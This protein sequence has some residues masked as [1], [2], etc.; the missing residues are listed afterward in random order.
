MEAIST[1]ELD[2]EDLEKVAQMIRSQDFA[3]L[4]T[5]YEEALKKQNAD[6]G[7]NLFELIS[8]YYYRETLHTHILYS[9]LDP[10]GKHDAKDHYLHLFLEFIRSQGAAIEVDDYESAE[11]E[12]EQ[13]K[14]D[15]LILGKKVISGKRKAI[16][17]ENKINCAVDQPRQLPGYLQKLKNRDNGC[18]KC[19][20][21][22]YLRLNGDTPPGEHGWLEDEKSDVKSLLTIISAYN[23]TDNDLRTG[24]IL[25]C[26]DLRDVGTSDA[27][28][29]LGQY[30][31]I[32]RKLGA[33]IMNEPIMEQF[34]LKM[35]DGGNLKTA[36]HLKMMLDELI[37]YRVKQI[38]HNFSLNHA[39]FDELYFW[40]SN[41]AVFKL[42]RGTHNLQMVVQANNE[43]YSL[44]FWDVNFTGTG[45]NVPEK[46]LNK[47]D[48]F[49]DYEYENVNR[50]FQLKKTFAFPGQEL[51]LKQHIE[52]FSEKLGS[53]LKGDETVLP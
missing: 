36:L 11:V 20:A 39:P 25:K 30:G 7:F 33:N 17:I 6:I 12:E 16:I 1:D 48:C 31:E 22:I 46:L 52:M 40:P 28:H 10:N 13:G 9:L 27:K 37:A 32:I 34:Y 35:H 8:E 19:D 21:I 15:L 47:I 5:Q 23:N 18:Y 26:K 53:V 42:S 24:W 3:F 29:I 45:E 38:I 49:D 44:F 2:H 14:I 50:R 51:E 4:A 43:N 41:L